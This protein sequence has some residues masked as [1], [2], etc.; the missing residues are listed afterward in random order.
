MTQSSGSR[1]TPSTA[2]RA[3]IQ[4]YIDL[5]VEDDT[6]EALQR[7][8][9]LEA[10]WGQT[11]ESDP[12]ELRQL[13]KNIKQSVLDAP[14]KVLSP[15][16]FFEAKTSRF[17]LSLILDPRTKKL[18]T[19]RRLEELDPGFEVYGTLRQVEE[20]IL[21][22]AR[23]DRFRTLRPGTSERIRVQP[24]QDDFPHY[25]ASPF[26]TMSLCLLARARNA[27]HSATTV[28]RR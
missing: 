7:L 18:R 4:L 22:P 25:R 2:L 23:A 26:N 28:S 1:C 5:T 14:R 12:A 3:A 21:I 19:L 24:A 6:D 8:N 16:G 9:D 11:H 10:E 15:F 13:H 27:L 20:R 17:F